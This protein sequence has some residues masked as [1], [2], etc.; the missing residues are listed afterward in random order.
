[1]LISILF[2]VQ[3]SQKPIFSFEKGS[4]G[5]NHSSPGSHHLVKKIPPPFSKISDPP[6]LLPSLTAFWETLETAVQKENMNFEK[7]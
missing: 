1:M 4:N 3:Y 6:L 7:G 2:D 5:Q